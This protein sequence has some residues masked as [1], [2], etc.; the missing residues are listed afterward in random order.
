MRNTLAA[1]VLACLVGWGCASFSTN[2]YRTEQTAVN[3][4]YTAFV[5]W[6]NYLAT[7]TPPP[8]P[9]TVA[10]VKEARLK[11]AATAATVEAL[12]VSYETNSALKQPL[13]AAIAT[14]TD[15]S[16]NIVWIIT[17]LKGK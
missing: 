13:Q 11:F 17:Y 6:T 3:I 15:Q 1:I 14:M 8:S 7:A 2:T 16:S 9:Q 12:R 10:A 4:A 5:G